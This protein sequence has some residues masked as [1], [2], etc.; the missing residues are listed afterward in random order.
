VAYRTDYWFS[1]SIL[2]KPVALFFLTIFI[3]CIGAVLYTLA[4]EERL[5]AP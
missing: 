2:A 1:I 4:S 5:E 3:I